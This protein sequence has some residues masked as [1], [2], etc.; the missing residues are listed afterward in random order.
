M[1][2]KVQRPRLTYALWI[3]AV[4]ATGLGT[5]SELAEAL[6][7]F[8]AT[9][10][11]DTL[12]ALTLFLCLGFVFARAPIG[13]LALV[14]LLGSFAVEFSQLYQADWANELRSTRIGAL[15][16]GKG[17]LASDLICYTVGVAVGAVTEWVVLDR[18]A[19]EA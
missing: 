5:R 10:A 8:I 13:R 6:P 9:Y 15:L 17:F 7:E 3:V 2:T 4:I 16:L 11:G 19:D 18:K 12:W 14:A 1:R